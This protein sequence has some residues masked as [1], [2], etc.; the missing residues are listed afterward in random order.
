M[1]MAKSVEEYLEWNEHWK[2]ELE[3]LIHLLRE[4]E[5]EETLK[6]GAPTY[7]INGKNVVGLGAFK[8]Y[9]G[10]WFHQSVFLG[11]P[12]IALMNA[13]EDKTKGLR[14]WR[15]N[16]INE[17]D[18]DLIKSYVLEAIENQKKGLTIK[19]ET[20][21]T[22]DMP[23]LLKRELEAN[24]SLKKAFDQFTMGKQKEFAT[25]IAEAK[26][27]TTKQRRLEKIIP[28]ILQGV[29]LNDKYR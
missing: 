18:F 12:A 24:S 9:V 25:Y 22:F 23:D 8:S 16:S 4:T 27:E 1:K 2:D 28:M 3:A 17:M 21:K 19:V 6:W 11:D 5:A 15:F 26:Q 14:Q 29:G 20:K 13:G 10:L 7:C